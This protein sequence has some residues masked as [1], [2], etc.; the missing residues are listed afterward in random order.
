[1]GTYTLVVQTEGTQDDLIHGVDALKGVMVVACMPGA[2]P[3][4]DV[5]EVEERGRFDEEVMWETLVGVDGLTVKLTMSKTADGPC[6]RLGGV[7]C[8]LEGEMPGE[9][10]LRPLA[11]T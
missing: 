1:M 8:D 3:E 5:E 10:Y 11:A 4:V 6:L 2:I 9:Y 7:T